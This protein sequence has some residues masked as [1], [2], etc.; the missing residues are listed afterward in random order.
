[1]LFRQ[2]F[3]AVLLVLSLFFSQEGEVT[4]LWWSL[5]YIFH[6]T[7]LQKDF[8][9]Y[10]GHFTFSSCYGNLF[11]RCCYWL[12]QGLHV[13]V[14]VR[15]FS[16]FLFYKLLLEYLLSSLQWD[17]L[18][19]FCKAPLCSAQL[20]NQVVS[21]WAWKCIGIARHFPAVFSLLMVLTKLNIN[22]F[23]S[24]CFEELGKAGLNYPR[25]LFQP[26]L[27][28]GSTGTPKFLS[29]LQG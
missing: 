22:L 28:C 20:T 11:S 8:M 24:K 2:R 21:F 15:F 27:C 9:I 4:A 18:F 16:S 13:M 5:E 1:M 3:Q 12:P 29:W 23:N 7:F 25:G 10:F 14:P 19:V 26:K 6:L 17:C